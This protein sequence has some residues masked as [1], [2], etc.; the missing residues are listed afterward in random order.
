M[1]R[2]LTLQ[3][4]QDIFKTLHCLG[5]IAFEPGETKFLAKGEKGKDSELPIDPQPSFYIKC[6]GAQHPHN[7]AYLD[8]SGDTK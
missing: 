8:G 1:P 6:P 2:T 3:L 7:A 5:H 4:G